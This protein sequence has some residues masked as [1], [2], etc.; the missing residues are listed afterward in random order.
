MKRIIESD[1]VIIDD[2]M[3][4]AMDK[5]EANLFFQLINKL[6][7]QTALIITSN[8]GPED[9]GDLLGDPAITMAIL[10]RIIHKSEIIHL[11]GDSQRIKN[12][13]TIFGKP[14]S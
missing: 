3:F 13:Q 6:Y 1:M 14:D 9:W 12:R 8:K 4:M 5:P 7:G 2:L 10:D 11:T